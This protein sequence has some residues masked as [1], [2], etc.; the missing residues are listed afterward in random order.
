MTKNLFIAVRFD[1]ATD[2]IIFS[3]AT[4]ARIFMDLHP[5]YDELLESGIYDSAKEA[6]EIWGD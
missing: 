1:G 5:E 2:A 6:L 3:D 4:E